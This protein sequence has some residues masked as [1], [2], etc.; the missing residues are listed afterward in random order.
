VERDNLCD[1]SIITQHSG[2]IQRRFK[3]QFMMDYYLK[4]TGPD[5]DDPMA[6]CDYISKNH[7]SIIRIDMASK[8]AVRSIRNEKINFEN[9]L[10]TLGK[11]CFTILNVLPSRSDFNTLIRKI[12]LFW[13]NRASVFNYFV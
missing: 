9:Q 7:L 2:L 4:N 3:L 6:V 11:I 10:A 12:I 8:S 5:P 1:P 13:E